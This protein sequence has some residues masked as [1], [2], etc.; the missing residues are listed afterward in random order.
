MQLKTLM[1]TR[2]RENPSHV[3]F[4]SQLE[5]AISSVTPGARVDAATVEGM[6]SLV[7]SKEISP[8]EALSCFKTY[9]R[10]GKPD[11]QYNTLRVLIQFVD[12][13]P[14]LANMLHMELASRRWRERFVALAGSSHPEVW[15][16]LLATLQTWAASYRAHDIGMQYQGTLRELNSG[17]ASFRPAGPGYNPQYTGYSMQQT[18]YSTQ[19]TGAGFPIPPPPGYPMH[20]PPGYPAAAPGYPAYGTLPPPQS[21]P[22]SASRHTQEN[23]PQKL[24]QLVSAL[25][26]LR[27]AIRTFE[28]TLKDYKAQGCTFAALS[29]AMDK[30]QRS[31]DRCSTLQTQLESLM[32][33]SDTDEALT[34]RVF[35]TNDAV[36]A[37]LEQW[38]RLA[39]QELAP[40]DAPAASTAAAASSSVAGPSTSAVPGPFAAPPPSQP[41][42]SPLDLLLGDELPAPSPQ[43]PVAGITPAAVPPPH[44]FSSAAS[45]TASNAGAS[46][47]NAF[48]APAPG[49]Y[50]T[51]GSVS[52][53]SAFPAASSA[54]SPAN[55]VPANDVEGLRAQVL[56]LASE[57]ERERKMHKTA[58][59]AQEAFHKQELERAKV[60]AQGRIT[61]LEST[62]AL[63]RQASLQPLP[64]GGASGHNAPLGTVPPPIPTGLSSN[65]PFAPSFSTTPSYISMPPP[66]AMGGGEDIFAS[67]AMSPST[68]TGSVPAAPASIAGCT[69]APPPYAPVSP[70]APAPLPDVFSAFDD[71]GVLSSKSGRVGVTAPPVASAAPYA[72]GSA[73]GDR[74]GAAVNA[75]GPAGPA[76]ASWVNF[77]L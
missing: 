72:F 19:P 38:S 32:G 56:A 69:V 43:P 23:V 46:E 42:P 21:L 63:A 17:G 15:P 28:T 9:F 14:H 54:A 20:A 62:L 25:E 26:V 11:E 48:A 5:T 57:L 30:G 52:G 53:V 70:S 2:F 7:R 13:D 68:A 36:M 75:S 76:A 50:P 31:A 16:L 33:T 51:V 37:A 64:S 6:L 66:P 59:D 71:L 41:P 1:G 10:E 74:K 8:G 35:S 58:L 34:A 67:L 18:G 45:G 29:A 47:W 73:S 12:M 4:R 61:E 60:Q 27:E 24:E 77:G 44:P 55:I 65:N 40:D 22:Q 39:N 3:K 49:P